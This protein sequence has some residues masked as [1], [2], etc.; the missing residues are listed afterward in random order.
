MG[1]FDR[2]FGKRRPG[3]GRFDRKRPGMFGRRDDDRPAERTD[4]PYDR[5]DRF[6]ERRDRPPERRDRPSDRTEMFS[7]IC[8]KCGKDCEVPFRPTPGKPL[9]CDD[10][11]KE[12]SREAGSRSVLGKLAPD[13]LDQINKKLDR[14]LSILEGPAIKKEK[15][16]HEEQP[17]VIPEEKPEVIAEEKPL[18]EKPKKK[19]KK[20]KP[21]SDN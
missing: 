19:A 18:E 17:K 1:D 5:R 12:K 16:V 21:A 11:F 8:D 7:G 6:S 20:K 3:R 9:F 13:S 2:N 14:I 4:R 10:C 15:K